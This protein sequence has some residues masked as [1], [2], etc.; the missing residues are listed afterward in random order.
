MK[1]DETRKIDKNVK[2][3]NA[4]MAVD[5]AMKLS[6]AR[7]KRAHKIKNAAVNDTFSSYPLLTIF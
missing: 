7:N 1:K 5:S 4:A 2:N 3:G 6:G